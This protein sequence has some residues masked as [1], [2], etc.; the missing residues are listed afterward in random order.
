MRKDNDLYRWRMREGLS[1]RKT[2]VILGISRV[3]LLK[4]EKGEPVG[5]LIQYKIDHKTE[6]LGKWLEEQE[7]V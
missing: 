3:T 2:A 4:Y 5:D 7:H 1:L 6:T